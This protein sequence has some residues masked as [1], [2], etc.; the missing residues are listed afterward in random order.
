MTM[1]REQARV[2]KECR[3]LRKSRLILFG[4]YAM[5]TA[6]GGLC[7]FI[8]AVMFLSLPIAALDS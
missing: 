1:T 7:I 4:L 6:L 2:I 8:S 5:F 3:K